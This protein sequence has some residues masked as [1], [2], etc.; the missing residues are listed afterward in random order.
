MRPFSHAVV[1]V[2]L[3]AANEFYSLTSPDRKVH[4]S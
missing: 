1:V 2:L 3:V 4:L